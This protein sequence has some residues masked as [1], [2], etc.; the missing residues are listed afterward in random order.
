MDLLRCVK[1]NYTITNFVNHRCL[2][3]EH[4]F[5]QESSQNARLQF[6]ET[7]LKK[8]LQQ[9]RIQRKE[10]TLNTLAFMNRTSTFQSSTFPQSTK[11]GTPLEC[12]QHRRYGCPVR[13]E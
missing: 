11:P 3:H 5:D 12:E 1:C 6:S 4:S 9:F 8:S 13:F 2:Y 10:L 7:T